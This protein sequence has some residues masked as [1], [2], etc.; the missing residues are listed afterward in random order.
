MTDYVYSVVGCRVAEESGVKM[1]EGFGLS[2]RRERASREE[3]RMEGLG[4]G[5]G[6]NQ[7]PI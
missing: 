7:E 4:K 5:P 3:L 2:G 6:L 1:I